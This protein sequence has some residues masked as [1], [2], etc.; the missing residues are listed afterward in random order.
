MPDR[1]G[2]VSCSLDLQTVDGPGVQ[3]QGTP[4]TQ[5]MKVNGLE[6]DA[7]SVAA[8]LRAA[9]DRLDPRPERPSHLLPGHT[10]GCRG[11][12]METS[13]SGRTRDVGGHPPTTH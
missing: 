2:L 7:P 6:A 5:I 10:P 4:V 11:M 13:V 8:L 9:A 12:G 3:G 1:T